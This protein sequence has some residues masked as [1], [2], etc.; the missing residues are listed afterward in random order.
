MLQQALRAAVRLLALDSQWQ[1]PRDEGGTMKV[2]YFQKKGCVTSSLE[3][4]HSR[5]QVPG[6]LFLATPALRM[7]EHR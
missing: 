7:I 2:R 4:D 1:K 6:A 3:G 5:L